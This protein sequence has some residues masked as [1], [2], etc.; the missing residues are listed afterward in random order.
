MRRDPSNQPGHA[1]KRNLDK[2]GIEVVLKVNARL[3][4]LVNCQIN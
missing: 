2:V 3:V 1:I 4:T